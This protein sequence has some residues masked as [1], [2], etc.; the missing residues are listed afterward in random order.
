V[1]NTLRLLLLL[2]ILVG[3]TMAQSSISERI[4]TFA[5]D[6]VITETK[7]SDDEI[8]PKN[9]SV[10]L[11]G[12]NIHGENEIENLWVVGYFKMFPV[13]MIL[14]ETSPNGGNRSGIFYR[15]ITIRSNVV[16]NMPTYSVSERF[17]NGL[18]PTISKT[19]EIITFRFP[20]GST[21]EGR[22]LAQ[23]W[24]WRGGSEYGVL[25]R[26]TQRRR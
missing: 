17:G 11:D 8:G 7:T 3:Q 9:Y 15:A 20:T 13:E 1:K 6:L 2:F 19:A 21:V 23:T 5:G 10:Q 26:V 25:Q 18:P 14:V 4:K 16:R 22:T 12:Q 24:V